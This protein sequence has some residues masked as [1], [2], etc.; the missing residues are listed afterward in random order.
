MVPAAQAD[1]AAFL[2]RLTGA[3]PVETHISAIFLGPDEAIKLRKAVR[4]GFVD[5]TTLAAREHAARRELELNAPAAPGM[6]RDVQPISRTPEGLALGGTGEVIDWVVR[7][8][9]VP[10]GDF[11]DVIAAEGRLTPALLVEIADSVA[12]LHADLPRATLDQA[13][14][15]R[16]ITLG[17]A[18]S[19]LDAGLDPPTVRSWMEG[20][21]DWVAAHG[22][23]LRARGRAGFV[24]RGH[25][26]LHLGNL[27]LWRGHPVA[28]DALEF[29]EDLATMDLGYDLGFLLM[30]LDVRASR[31]AANLV[32]N[33]YVARTGDAA[34][35][36]G[37]P[38]FLSQRAM[39]RAHV[40]AARFKPVEAQCY[41]R[42]A[43]AYLRPTAPR[44]VAIGGL[45]GAG[46]STLARLLAPEIGNAPGALV[47]RSDEIR[48]RLFGVAPETRLPPEAYAEEVSTRVFQTIAEATREALALGHA[49]IADATFMS[50]AHRALIAEAASG[51][52][53]TGI[54]LDVPPALL[55][56]RVAAR[57]GDASDAD[58]AILDRAL[59]SAAGAGDWRSVDGQDT[60]AAL[61]ACRTLCRRNML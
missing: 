8:A 52:T 5:F 51:A 56:S 53:F 57:K 19:G 26:D 16:D 32:L 22:D 39:V 23:W 34:I 18:F 54:W 36:G 9:R 49:V 55:R 27:C 29:N 61:A 13:A 4:P 58:L 24:R 12:A 1:T 14:S 28:F 46:K 33:R 38:L 44:V 41:L 40:Q 48:K 21:L 37:L 31:A 42:R 25:G 6:Y 15:I 10:A 59:A 60:D 3:A 45:P 17:N 50:P 30:D 35:V 11:L 7:M 43:L 2:Q 20:S 47:L